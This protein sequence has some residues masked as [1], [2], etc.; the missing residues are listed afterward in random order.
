[1]PARKDPIVC[2]VEAFVVVGIIA[3]VF[4]VP[5]LFPQFFQ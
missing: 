4:A 5:R 2:A 1:M 3:L